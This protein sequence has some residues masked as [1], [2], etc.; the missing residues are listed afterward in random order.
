MCV[1]C[2]ACGGENY[3]VRECDACGGKTIVDLSGMGTIVARWF[4]SLQ[5]CL[6]AEHFS[7]LPVL[8][9]P[10]NRSRK[11]LHEIHI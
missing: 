10:P 11:L 3:C 5:Y 6:E 2:D 1:L 8:T 9:W 7:V 4:A